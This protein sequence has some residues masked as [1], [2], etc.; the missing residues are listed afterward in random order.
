MLNA[1]LTKLTSLVSKVKKQKQVPAALIFTY[2][3]WSTNFFKG[4]LVTTQ[5]PMQFIG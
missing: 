4:L 3:N 2:Q 5:K 1:N